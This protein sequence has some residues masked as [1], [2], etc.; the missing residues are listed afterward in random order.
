MEHDRPD[1]LS[2]EDKIFTN[3]LSKATT[4]MVVITFNFE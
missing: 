2:E 4:R 1:L 3:A